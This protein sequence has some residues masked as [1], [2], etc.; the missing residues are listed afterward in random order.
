MVGQPGDM[1]QSTANLG[2]AK[3][4]TVWKNRQR[5]ESALTLRTRELFMLEQI[6]GWP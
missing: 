2:S 4:K 3:R 5:S 1:H 6:A